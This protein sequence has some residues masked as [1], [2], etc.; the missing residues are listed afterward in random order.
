MVKEMYHDLFKGIPIII[1][2]LDPDEKFLNLLASIR[3]D[4][5]TANASV[6]VVNDGS[7]SNYNHYFDEAKNRY[8]VHLLTH[9]VNAGKGQALKTAFQ[10]VIEKLPA[11][12]GVVTIDSDGQ[13][14]VE[15]MAKC[16]VAFSKTP[17]Q[18]I[19]GSR[20]FTGDDVPLKSRVGNHT[21]AYLVKSMTAMDLTDT[22]TGLRVIPVEHLA[23][24]LNLE[25]DR[26][27]FEMNMIYY[28]KDEG[29]SIL[30]VPIETIYIEENESTHFRPLMDSMQIYKR[31]IRYVFS[32]L[33]CFVIDISLFTFIL[34]IFPRE[35]VTAVTTATVAARLI[36]AIVNYL[37]DRYFVFKRG[38]KASAI[39]YFSLVGTYMLLSSL[40][41]SF[42]NHAFPAHATVIKVAI[43]LSLFLI[44]Y[45]V[46]RFFIFGGKEK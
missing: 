25:G 5:K 44:G 37:L 20:V 39:K 24:M 12:K 18:I 23:P 36:A 6:I 43:D 22:Q 33:L 16:V 15:D 38:S 7:A 14:T 10:Y 30:E 27:E 17:H 32:S 46:E 11:T 2:S 8:G 34:T 42:F 35:T 9:Q 28:A 31:F 45:L 19:F 41:V 3:N 1:P 29:V 26:F 4:E 13:H 40:L 21:T